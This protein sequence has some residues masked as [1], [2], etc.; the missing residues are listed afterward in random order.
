MLCFSWGR[1]RVRESGNNNL[2]IAA[3]RVMF[4]RRLK[5]AKS[6]PNRELSTPPSPHC[7][8]VIML[9]A[10]VSPNKLRLESEPGTLRES[11]KSTKVCNK[12]ALRDCTMYVAENIIHLILQPDYAL[13]HF[14]SSRGLSF[15]RWNRTKKKRKSFHRNLIEKY[16]LP[17]FGLQ[18]FPRL[19]NLFDKSLMLFCLLF[20]AFFPSSVFLLFL[21][22]QQLNSFREREAGRG[23]M[24]EINK[25]FVI[26]KS[27]KA[28]LLN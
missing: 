11:L 9:Y 23:R 17:I 8:T 14:W 1:A 10:L 15:S 16:L 18:F 6:S 21:H 19:R 25:A 28:K 27:G 22:K 5:T 3:L 24:R 26:E 4:R 13:I 7:L 2:P 12:F 20:R